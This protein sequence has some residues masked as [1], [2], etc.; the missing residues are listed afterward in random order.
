MIA[1]IFV[2]ELRRARQAAGISQE[3]LAEMI[4]YSPSQVAMVE[5]GKRS[6]SRDFAARCDK[7]LGT[8]GLLVRLQER[9]LKL[10]STPQWFRPWLEIEPQATS[11]RTY[12]PLLVPGL[13]QTE[14]YASALLRD[15]ARVA[16]RMERQRI[17]DG[18]ESFVVVIDEAAVTR[19]V[20]GPE[21]MAEQLDRLLTDERAV[22][23]VVP[24]GTGYYTGLDGAFTLA[25]LDGSEVAVLDNRLRGQVVELPED[26]SVIRTAWE[27]VRSEAL[28]RG[29]SRRL[30]EEVCER[31][32][33]SAGASPA[34]RTE[35]AGTA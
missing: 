17:L 21:V 8:G 18:L 13:L 4:Q 15:E 14:R 19:P 24:A 25:V 26:L 7:A 35:A 29:Q 28:P 2:D 32:K 23:H 27:A 10:E 1:E 5:T 11:L 16:T 30:L 6:P 20:G 12:G 33:A 34:G 22:V 9:L 31:W 3:Q